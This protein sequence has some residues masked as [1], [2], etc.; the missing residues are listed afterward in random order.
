MSEDLGARISE[1]Q[2]QMSATKRPG[3]NM[4]PYWPE[5]DFVQIPDYAARAAARSE[6]TTIMFE[7]PDYKDT[8]ERALEEGIRRSEEVDARL[9]PPKPGC[10][11]AVYGGVAAAAGVAIGIYK[12]VEWL[13]S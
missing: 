2:A 11:L 1:L 10:M 8:A 5:S 3:P 7:N 9:E 12:L 13:I 4:T 6:L